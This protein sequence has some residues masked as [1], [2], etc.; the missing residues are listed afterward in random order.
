MEARDL[1]QSLESISA[2]VT[3]L[4]EVDL[5]P[6]PKDNPNLAAG[7]AG[8]TDLI[9]SGDKQDVPALRHVEGIPIVSPSRGSSPTASG[10][11]PD[12]AGHPPGSFSQADS[13]GLFQLYACLR[14]CAR[15][16]PC[17]KA[18]STPR[19]LDCRL[20][21]GSDFAGARCTDRNTDRRRWQESE[22]MGMESLRPAVVAD[23][24]D[25]GGPREPNGTSRSG[26]LDA[27]TPC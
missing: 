4:P 9:V 7:L 21:V 11:I 22:A 2:V 15:I 5:S 6:D 10:D 17:P 13:T 20:G 1:L 25:R 14:R 3:E 12:R 19:W 18:G 16:G 23:P 24:R 27:T 8:R 26:A